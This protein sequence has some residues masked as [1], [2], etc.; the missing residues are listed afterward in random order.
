VS[1][2]K[3]AFWVLTGLGAILAFFVA[4]KVHLSFGDQP[5]PPRAV[6]PAPKSP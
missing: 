1:F 4:N 5:S 6:M 2:V 3:G